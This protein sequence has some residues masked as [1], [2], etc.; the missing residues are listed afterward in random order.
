MSDCRVDLESTE[1]NDFLI[2]VKE[3]S[4]RLPSHT[5]FMGKA[6][7]ETLYTKTGCFKKYHLYAVCQV[8]ICLISHSHEL[9]F[10]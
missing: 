1:M 10:S 5:V 7:L 9:C 2:L 8:E 4:P 6:V 3:I